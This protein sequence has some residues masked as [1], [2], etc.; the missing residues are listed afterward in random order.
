MPPHVDLKN[1]EHFV[2]QRSTLWHEIWKR[3]VVSAS[4]A[5]NALGLRSLKE[6]KIHHKTYVQKT[7]GPKK[8]ANLTKKLLH[9]TESEVR[10]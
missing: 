1:N 3:C 9:G 4:S 7:E 6:Q 10:I 2:K 5:F 8:D